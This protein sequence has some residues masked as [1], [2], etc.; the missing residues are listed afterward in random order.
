MA[1]LGTN[2][3]EPTDPLGKF[4][5]GGCAGSTATAPVPPFYPPTC[6]W[7]L[8]TGQSLDLTQAPGKAK[9]TITPATTNPMHVGDVCN[10]GIFCTPGLSNRNLLDFISEA[11]DPTTGCAHVAYADDSN[12]NPKLQFLR[13]ANQVSGPSIQGPRACGARAAHPVTHHHH[14]VHHHPHHHPRPFRRPK[15]KHARG[16]TG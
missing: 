6:R 14:H 12:P 4:D 3:T 15:K 2:E 8:F 10:L 1:W 13:A 11:V 9:F 16:F 7:N 5:P